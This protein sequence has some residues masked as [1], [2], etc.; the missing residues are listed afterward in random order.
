MLT[1][2]MFLVGTVLLSIGEALAIAKKTDAEMPLTYYI[3]EF[4]KKP[5]PLGMFVAL[6]VWLWLGCH[7]L[8]YSWISC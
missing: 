3:R 5:G 7:F 8:L 1:A 4:F 2:I 6:G